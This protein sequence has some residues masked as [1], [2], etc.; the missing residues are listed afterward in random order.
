[1]NKIQFLT[2]IDT[3]EC[4]YGTLLNYDAKSK[5]Y[6]RVHS[7][8]PV[9]NADKLGLIPCRQIE[10]QHNKLGLYLYAGSALEFDQYIEVLKHIHESHSFMKGRSIKYIDSCIDTRDFRNF[11]LT[12]RQ[13]SWKMIITRF[14]MALI[15]TEEDLHAAPFVRP[16]FDTIMAFLNQN[17]ERVSLCSLK[18]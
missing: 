18:S 16:M 8:K 12:L 2:T 17:E 9:I 7:N 6:R 1:M 14:D 10:D 3:H 13:S 5:K 4:G 11:T 15:P